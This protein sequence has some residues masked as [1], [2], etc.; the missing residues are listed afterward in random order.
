MSFLEKSKKKQK[1][2]CPLILFL[3]TIE[4]Y[5]INKKWHMRPLSQSPKLRHLT[6]SPRVHKNDFKSSP[7][8][9]LIKNKLKTR[10]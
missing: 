10:C 5:V 8:F 2:N 7:K 1:L 9:F 4:L 6:F 3:F